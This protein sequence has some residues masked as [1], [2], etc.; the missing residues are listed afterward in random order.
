MGEVLS[1]RGSE[2]AAVC[3]GG[4]RMARLLEDGKRRVEEED[5]SEAALARR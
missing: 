4:G 3:D 1:W 5:A 2:G